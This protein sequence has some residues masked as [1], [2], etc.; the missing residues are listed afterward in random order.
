MPPDKNNKQR[1]IFRAMGRI[2]SLLQ[3]M[4]K[5]P[6]E[7]WV[8]FLLLL[9]S[10]MLAVQSVASMERVPTPGLYLLALSGLVLG[11]LLAKMRFN[12]WLLAVGGM[13]LGIYA[14]FCQVSSLVEGATSLDRYSYGA[15][16]W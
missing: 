10:V 5:G 1:Y 7:G 14:S 2:E 13:L 6:S 15:K 12:G 9:F 11:L 4:V 8:T 16:H 3:Q